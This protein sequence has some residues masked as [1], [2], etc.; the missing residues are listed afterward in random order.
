[1]MESRRP[2]PPRNVRAFTLTDGRVRVVWDHSPTPGVREYRLYMGLRGRIKF[3]SPVAV[4]PAS[5]QTWTSPSPFLAELDRETYVHDREHVFLA[6]TPAEILSWN[7]RYPFVVRAATEEAEDQNTSP[8]V[9]RPFWS[10]TSRNDVQ[11][12]AI[13]PTGEVW[14]RTEGGVSVF[15]GQAWLTQPS[16]SDWARTGPKRLTPPSGV[17]W[18]RSGRHC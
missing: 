7:P 4:V 16:V 11:S 10:H 6:E 3:D 14:C 12:V 15:D 17:A 1:M 18:R 2:E 8:A 5:Q 13:A 9:P